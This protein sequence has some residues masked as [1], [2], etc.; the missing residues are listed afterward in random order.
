[1]AKSRTIN[2]KIKNLK[3]HRRRV[4]QNKFTICFLKMKGRTKLKAII[5]IMMK[6]FTTDLQKCLPK[7]LKSN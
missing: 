7:N 4:N 1:M 6:V 5:M 3:K 2:R